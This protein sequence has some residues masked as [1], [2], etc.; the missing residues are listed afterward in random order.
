MEWR[1]ASLS[2]FPPK[3]RILGGVLAGSCKPGVCCSLHKRSFNSALYT[4]WNLRSFNGARTL[5]IFELKNTHP[6]HTHIET[7]LLMYTHASKNKDPVGK[8]C[9]DVAHDSHNYLCYKEL[10]TLLPS[11]MELALVI[12]GCYAGSVPSSN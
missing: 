5:K 2:H 10:R 1:L 12:S 11:N 3:L 7:L 6:P 8:K 9:T 4:F